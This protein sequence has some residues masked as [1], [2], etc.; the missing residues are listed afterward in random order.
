LNNNK[1]ASNHI[2]VQ[3]DRLK[4]YGEAS[5]NLSNGA[6]DGLLKAT[7]TDMSESDQVFK[8]QDILGGSFPIQLS[9]KISNPKIYPDFSIIQ[10]I[11]NR[12]LLEHQMEKPL[13][14]LK[15]KLNSLLK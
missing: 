6:I 12:Y 14:K 5:I 2:S 1:I 15:D 11:L 4:L 13:N 8:A 3:T 10:P 7:V 9:G